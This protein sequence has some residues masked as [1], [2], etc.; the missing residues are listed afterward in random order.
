MPPIEEFRKY[1]IGGVAMFDL[2]LTFFAAY[3]IDKLVDFK[4]KKL[5]YLSMLPLAVLS[6]I[7]VGQKTFVNSQ[8]FSNEINNVKLV[9]LLIFLAI[10]LN[11]L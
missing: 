7:I 11:L 9:F 6:H 2:I 1:R 8:L 3:M 10:I 5:Y 4:Y